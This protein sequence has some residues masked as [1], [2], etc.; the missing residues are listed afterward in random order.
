M[1]CP[2]C[3]TRKRLFRS[4]DKTLIEVAK[5]IKAKLQYLMNIIQRKGDDPTAVKVW[6]A[7][8]KIWKSMTKDM[9]DDELDIT[10]VVDGYDFKVIKEEGAKTDKGTFP[11]YDASKIQRKS[12]TL[13]DEEKTIIT[14]LDNRINLNEI[15]KFEAAEVL[16]GAIDAYIKALTDATDEEFYDD[17][18]DESDEKTKIETT[19]K[20]STK[21]KTDLDDFKKKLKSKL[22]ED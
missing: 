18:E 14:I 13:S 5:E 9:L 11:N 6:G 20:K 10:D 16:Q 8:V 12:T 1:R 22:K 3:E 4:G 15:P 2:I 21:P 19:A 7:G 17:D